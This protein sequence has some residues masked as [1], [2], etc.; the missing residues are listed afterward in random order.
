MYYK[1]GSP[2][3]V[4]RIAGVYTIVLHQGEFRADALLL[5]SLGVQHK[6]H[7]LLWDPKEGS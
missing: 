3:F 4:L 7:C 1:D 2:S 6:L 5:E